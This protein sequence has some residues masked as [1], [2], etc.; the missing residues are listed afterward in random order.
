MPSPS[1]A[2]SL[3]PSPWKSRRLFAVT[4]TSWALWGSFIERRDQ[5]TFLRGLLVGGLIGIVSHY[6]CWYFETTGYFFITFMTDPQKHKEIIDPL[7]AIWSSAVMSVYSLLLVGWIST[8][9]AMALGA[10]CGHF[11]KR[12]KPATHAASHAIQEHA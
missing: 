8:P 1:P 5:Y 7:T 4:G 9:I 12:R 10:A 3:S 6:V 2:P 11:G